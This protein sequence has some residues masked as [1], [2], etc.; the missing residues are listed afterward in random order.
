MLFFN[1][2]SLFTATAV[3]INVI[4]YIVDEDHLCPTSGVVLVCNNIQIGFCCTTSEFTDF[5]TTV[6]EGISTDPTDE[7]VAVAFAQVGNTRC[8]RVCESELSQNNVCMTCIVNGEDVISGGGWNVLP[9]ADES[10]EA[11]SDC[12]GSVQPDELKYQGR[13]YNVFHDVPES[14]SAQLID[15]VKR[16]VDVA[17][18]PAHLSQYEKKGT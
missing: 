1:I 11:L 14:I 13:S 12:K 3:A 5:P 15:L 4:L 17:D 9:R 10:T 7:Q 16:N 2:L 8:G 6:V 18:F